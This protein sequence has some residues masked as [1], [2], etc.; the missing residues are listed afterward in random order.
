MENHEQRIAVKIFYL[1]ELGYKKTYQELEDVLHESTI[2]LSSVKRW[3][4]R[5]KSG[6]L[7]C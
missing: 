7:T 5:F 4:Q 2:S 6:D 1:K 3:I